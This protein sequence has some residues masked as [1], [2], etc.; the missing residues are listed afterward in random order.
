[1]PVVRTA[2]G[3]IHDLEKNAGAQITKTKQKIPVIHA[4]AFKLYSL[5]FAH[6]RTIVKKEG[7]P[8]IALDYDPSRCGKVKYARHR[9]NSK[10]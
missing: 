4:N 2:S 8:L 6:R 7:E 9:V 10:H 1:M 5:G 3:R